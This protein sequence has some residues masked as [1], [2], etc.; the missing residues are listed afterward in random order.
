MLRTI[1]E[2]SKKF[3]VLDLTKVGVGRNGL[4]EIGHGVG[5]SCSIE[6]LKLRGNKRAYRAYSDESFLQNLRNC[7]SLKYI[8]IAENN[9]DFSTTSKYLNFKN[10]IQVVAYG[11]HLYEEILN[12]ATHAIGVCLGILGSIVLLANAFYVD[13]Y[14]FYSC[15]IYC[16]TTIFLYISSTIYHS[17]FGNKYLSDILKVFD[18]CAI[19]LMIAGSYTPFCLVNLRQH[20]LGVTFALTEWGFA[21]IGIVLTLINDRRPIPFHSAI[22]L[23]LYVGMGHLI[24]LLYDDLYDYISKEAIDLLV[25]GGLSYTVGIVFFLID[26]NGIHPLGH[27]VWHLFVLAGSIFHYFGILWYV[28]GLGHQ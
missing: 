13:R 8:D 1:L 22:E 9:L 19:F 26:T 3:K 7:A 11:N 20:D 12:T 17:H 27:V 24:V 23:C 2:K 5:N 14:V 15:L 10:K 16:F 18:H 25:Y 28:V 6:I 21:L 4:L